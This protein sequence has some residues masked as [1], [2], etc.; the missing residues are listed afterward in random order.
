MTLPASPASSSA[1][2]GH[3]RS[4]TP[5]RRSVATP[6]S[7][8]RRDEESG[9]FEGH[10]YN[11]LQLF[12]IAREVALLATRPGRDPSKTTQSA[13]SKAKPRSKWPDGPEPDELCQQ[14]PDRDGKPYRWRKLMADLFSGK[15]VQ[16]VDIARTQATADPLVDSERVFH[17][18]RRVAAF[19]GLTTLLPEDYAAGREALIKR[20]RARTKNGGRLEE[21]LP[22]L[23][24]ILVAVDDDWDL[25]L[26]W[27][28]L[29]PRQGSTL[30]QAAVPVPVEE[31]VFRFFEETGQM[32][33]LNWLLEY[34]A[35]K[36][37]Q[38][39]RLKA[40]SAGEAQ[41]QGGLALVRER[42]GVEPALYKRGAK[43]PLWKR[44]PDRRE[45][46]ARRRE[47]VTNVRATQALLEFLAVCRER[48]LRGGL[49]DYRR[50]RREDAFRHWPAAS[51]MQ[52]RGEW[53]Q[54]IEDAEQP[55]ALELAAAADLALATARAEEQAERRAAKAKSPRNYPAEHP[56]SQAILALLREQA[57][58]MKS[59]ELRVKFPMTQP[60]MSRHLQGLEL[61]GLVR[62]VAGGQARKYEAI[63][64]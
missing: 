59:K 27:A 58:P 39:P 54:Q 4:R 7:E 33:A 34:A 26:A 35:D 16:R 60:T 13:W 40:G 14:L 55:G 47:P 38:M 43:K 9:R 12:E 30:E 3:S 25:A 20:D 2:A 49:P 64:D 37:V 8:P 50:L 48:K 63:S 23:G 53:G 17:A 56:R 36:D 51:R 31:M 24:Q 61:A 57:R 42:L 62:S 46:E 10:S 44:T 11:R 28:E 15:S 21:I 29:E 18:L 1:A 41:L 52:E 22:T 19:R 32:P 45:G 6:A 5:Y